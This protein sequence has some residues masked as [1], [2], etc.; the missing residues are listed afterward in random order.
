MTASRRLQQPGPPR[1]ERWL[2]AAGLARVLD[3]VLEPGLTLNEAIARPLAAAGIAGGT[4]DLDGGALGPFTY[5][6]PALSDDP[7]FAAY[8]SRNYAPAGE[9]RFER[10]AATFGR[11]DGAPFV[12]CHGVWREPA[13]SRRGGH[14]MPLDTIVAAPI[15]ARAVGVA[16]ARFEVLPDAET[17][18]SI[19]APVQ[20]DAP[21]DAPG[22]SRRALLLKVQPNE[23]IDEA[24]AAA[25]RAHGLA[26]ARVHGVGSFVGAAFADGRYAPSIATEIFIERGSVRTGEV[27]LDITL[28]DVD[29]AIHAG[30]V[31]PGNPICITFELT[32]EEVDP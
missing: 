17:N 14:V 5:V 11:R 24:L 26:A 21:S 12:H 27:S 32:L 31:A 2:A 16:E 20:G 25:C 1:P 30:R 10:G 28:V 18:F 6:M 23:R 4:V 13:G 22:G 29:G 3:F 9:T 7:R 15:T 19:F 8:Y